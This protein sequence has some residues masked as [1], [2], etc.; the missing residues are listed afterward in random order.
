MLF[1]TLQTLVRDFLINEQTVRN[2]DMVYI[3]QGL[4]PPLRHYTL[5]RQYNSGRVGIMIEHCRRENTKFCLFEIDMFYYPSLRTVYFIIHEDHY[6]AVTMYS[7]DG[8]PKITRTSV[9]RLH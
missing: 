2:E 1:E 3:D 8:N 7:V 6:Y 5:N 4:I 9:Y